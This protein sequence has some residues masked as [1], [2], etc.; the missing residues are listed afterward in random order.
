M[1]GTLF[2]R[3]GSLLGGTQRVSDFHADDVPD[4]IRILKGMLEPKRGVKSVGIDH[5]LIHDNDA[6]G[7]VLLKCVGQLEDGRHHILEIGENT[8]EEK[9]DRL[10][11]IAL[12]F[13]GF[14]RKMFTEDLGL[15]DKTEALKQME[16]FNPGLP[17]TSQFDSSYSHMAEIVQSSFLH[18]NSSTEN[19]QEELLIAYLIDC[20]RALVTGESKD[21]LSEQQQEQKEDGKWATEVV[22]VRE[23]KEKEEEPHRDQPVCI[24]S[25]MVSDPGKQK[26][27]LINTDLD[28]CFET[29]KKQFAL[30]FKT[31]PGK[32]TFRYTDDDGFQWEVDDTESLRDFASRYSAADKV[33]LLCVPQQYASTPPQTFSSLV[34]VDADTSLSEKWSYFLSQYDV[35]N[36]GTLSSSE[37]CTLLKQDTAYSWLDDEGLRPPGAAGVSFIKSKVDSILQN[38]D[39]NHDGQVSYE[40]FC[41]LML[42]LS[43]I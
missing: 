15:S 43:Q 30:K 19:K 5:L 1:I 22:A 37:L 7:F 33:E 34:P 42:K 16:I 23:E 4:L 25:S 36:S 20:L 26:V 39:T 17:A 32:L 11:N 24:Y 21:S 14:V 3:G 9:C 10:M 29:M 40:E 12:V 13:A 28:E 35:D 31:A 27:V 8:V 2:I 6:E 38:H 18:V 41:V